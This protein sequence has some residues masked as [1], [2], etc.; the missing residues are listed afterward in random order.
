M[1]DKP[2]G[3]RFVARVAAEELAEGQIM[4]F[5]GRVVESGPEP[6]YP[7]RTRI[8]LVKELA[9]ADGDEREVVLSVPAD[10]KLSIGEPFEGELPVPVEP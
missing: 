9:A 2:R 8:V 10:M 6:D 3:L 4:V 5:D 7:D 1:T